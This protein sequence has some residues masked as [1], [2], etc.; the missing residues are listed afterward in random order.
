MGNVL[1]KKVVQKIKHTFYDH[2]FFPKNR[3]IYETIPKNTVETEGPHM[4][5][6]YGT[7]ALHAGLARLHALICVHTPT[8][9]G[10]NMHGRTHRSIS[11]N[12]CISTARMFP[13]RASMF[14]YS[15]IACLV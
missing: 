4:T 1:E 7:Y 14:R 3:N 6:Q 12:Y 10:T 9:P 11:N 13:E 15:Y 8:R 5:S 2:Q